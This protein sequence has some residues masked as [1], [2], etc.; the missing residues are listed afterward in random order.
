MLS[1]M[2]SLLDPQDNIMAILICGFGFAK[3][4]AG[5]RAETRLPR[6]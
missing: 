1:C 3:H 5:V 6:L 4:L 2:P